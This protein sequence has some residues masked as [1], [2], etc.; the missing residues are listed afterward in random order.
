MIFLMAEIK[1]LLRQNTK[2]APSDKLSEYCRYR[3]HFR[4]QHKAINMHGVTLF[5]LFLL[6]A[7]FLSLTKKGRTSNKGRKDC[8]LV[9][10]RTGNQ[11]TC[12]LFLVLPRTSS[13]TLG[14]SFNG[15]LFAFGGLNVGKGGLIFK[16]TA[17]K[18]LE[19]NS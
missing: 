5:V 10:E 9:K 3:V 8:L 2:A 19:L 6:R 14:K 18:S 11:E 7:L 15:K 4:E 1:F 13:A 17:D 16:G 12:N